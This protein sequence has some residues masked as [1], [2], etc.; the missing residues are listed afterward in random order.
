MVTRSVHGRDAA[1]AGPPPDGV[2]A[3]TRLVTGE[4]PRPVGGV[5]VGRPAVRRIAPGALPEPIRDAMPGGE[6]DHLD[7]RARFRLADLPRRARY[8]AAFLRLCF[9][10]RR[11]AVVHMD[12]GDHP[13]GAAAPPVAFS[14]AGEA[15]PGWLFG[16]VG[17]GAV[18]PPELAIHAIVRAPG[19]LPEVSGSIRVDASIERGR[20]RTRI[21]HARSETVPVFAM[22]PDGSVTE[23]VAVPGTAG[24]R[25]AAAAAGTVR[26]CMA[27][28]IERF[29]RFRNPEAVRA[30]ERFLAV[31]ENARR[32]AGIDDGKV[33]FQRSGDGQFA[34]LPPALD[35]SAAIP[36]LIEGL[37][38]SLAEVNHDLNE[39]AR[40]RLRVALHR[41]YVA[42]GVNGWIG[43]STIAVHRLLDSAPARE[44]L[45]AHPE[46]DFAL[47]VSGTIY[48]DVLAHGYGRLPADAFTEVTAE[49]PDKDFA[50]QAWVHVPAG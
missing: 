6:H 28:D 31:L 2:L 22:K 10:D 23:R 42:P 32:R 21:V 47:I 8:T 44:A 12:A 11:V 40:I 17:G 18:L 33:V 46:A 34:I 24:P 7:V 36:L 45:T 48:R 1:S 27:A 9:D 26:L 29:S 4:R 41:G 49:L 43:D 3:E 38:T 30:Q 37:R 19:D 39:H 50:E 5:T 25:S 14:D 13:S 15:A 16:D 20:Y 35:E